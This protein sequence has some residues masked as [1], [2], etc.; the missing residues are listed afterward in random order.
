MNPRTLLA[1][2]TEPDFL[3]GLAAGVGATV[4]MLASRNRI[5]WSL[6]W[7]VAAAG[8]L[9]WT[10]WRDSWSVLATWTMLPAVAW[11]LAAGVAV[12]ELDRKA[13]PW[14]VLAMFALAVLG[15]WGT[16]P[17]TEGAAVLMGVTVGMAP[18]IWPLQARAGAFGPFVA[19]TAVAVVAVVDGAPRPG[20][21]VG[22]LGAAGML[23]VAP[24]ALRIRRTA[25]AALSGWILVVT[26]VA[27][28]IVSGRL[29]GRMT[30]AGPAFTV[31]TAAAV[32]FGVAW[33]QMETRAGHPRA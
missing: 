17:D 27:F 19:F 20:S 8:G 15:V 16:V 28:V 4:L 2:L 10:E 24:A 3:H 30:P 11:V 7:G 18:A 12:R 6:C 23:L 25:P 9:L 32:A 13:P 1:L 29:A 21:I 33:W 26:Q 22:A 14:S 31:W 5:G